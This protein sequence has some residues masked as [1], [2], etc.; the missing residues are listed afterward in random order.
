MEKLYLSGRIGKT[1]YFIPHSDID[2]SDFSEDERYKY[3]MN[4]YDI[5]SKSKEVRYLK[6]FNEDEMKS[7]NNLEISSNVKTLLRFWYK[8]K[9][10]KPIGKTYRELFNL[11]IADIK[12]DPNGTCEVIKVIELSKITDYFN[13]INFSLDISKERFPYNAVIIY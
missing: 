12:L 11:S 10:N 5:I 13:E 3:A 6:Y 9:S 7:C 4:L 1:S 8:D 2:L